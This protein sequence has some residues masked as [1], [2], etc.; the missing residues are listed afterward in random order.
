M[1]VKG[2]IPFS[3]RTILR[4]FILLPEPLIPQNPTAMRF[5][6]LSSLKSK[7]LHLKK[8]IKVLKQYSYQMTF[9]CLVGGART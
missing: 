2:Q 3:N 7:S 4:I 5:R 6:A 1:G 8:G 9:V